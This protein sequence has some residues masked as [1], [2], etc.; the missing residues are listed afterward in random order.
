M[1][2]KL[3][4][5]RRRRKKKGKNQNTKYKIQ[6][7]NIQIQKKIKAKAIIKDAHHILLTD[8]RARSTVGRQR[9]VRIRVRGSLRG[10]QLTVGYTHHPLIGRWVYIHAEGSHRPSCIVTKDRPVSLK[11]RYIMVYKSLF[12]RT[13]E[14]RRL[15]INLLSS[16]CCSCDGLVSG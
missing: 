8:H 6:K 14:G 11:Y 3:A 7:E 15:C 5:T 1:G 9:Q 13:C 12:L 4:N 16:F 2:I 10:M